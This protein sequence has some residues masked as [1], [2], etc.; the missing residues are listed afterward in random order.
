MSIG[1][2]A[3]RVAHVHPHVCLIKMIKE[4]LRIKQPW[5][6][7]NNNPNMHQL[8]ASIRQTNGN[9]ILNDAACIY[10]ASVPLEEVLSGSSQDSW[11]PWRGCEMW[12]GVHSRPPECSRSEQFWEHKMKSFWWNP[13]DSPAPRG[14]NYT[15]SNSLGLFVSP[16]VLSSRNSHQMKVS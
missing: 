2:T 15:T 6:V 13:R 8:E 3:M 5:D 16:F 10:L 9:W 12:S 1:R 7:N 14:M 4:R 11:K